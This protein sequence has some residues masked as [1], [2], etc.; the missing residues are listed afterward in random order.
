M[1][2]SELTELQRYLSGRE[3]AEMD[4]L[5][6]KGTP[7][8]EPLTGS[9]QTEAYHS[10]ADFLF[11]GG[12][13][14]GGKTDLLVG[15]ALTRHRQSVIFRREYG[16]L[17]AIIHRVQNILSGRVGYNGQEKI[18]RLKDDRHLRFG[19]CQ[20]LGDEERF[21]GQPHDL[22]GFDEITHFLEAQFRFLVGWNR[23]DVTGQRCRV[24]ATGNPPRDAEG[25][26]VIK[27]W[28]PWLDPDHT[29]PALPGELRWFTTG[30]EGE[31]VELESGEPFEQNGE[32]IVPKSR[33]FI[34]SSVEDNPFL[35][36][37]GYKAMLQALPEPLRSQMLKGDF[38]AGKDDDPWQVIPTE[39]VKL[40]Q[41]RWTDRRP[42][43]AEMTA[44]GVDVARGGA[45]KTVLSPR[46]GHWFAEQKVQPGTATPDG[47][48]A[49]SFVM[50]ALRDGAPVQVDVIGV[51]GSVYDHLKGNGIDCHAMNGSE[52]SEQRDR[53]GQLTFA[54]R[55]AEWWWAM[56]EDL[57]PDYGSGLALPPDRNLLVDLCAPRWKLTTR[58][59]QVESKEDIVKRIGRSPDRGDAA[60][61][62]LPTFAKK[63]A[64]GRGVTHALGGYNP[65][66]W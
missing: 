16:Q 62:A 6:T 10:P 24:V 21:Q 20:H 59:V 64:R 52:K 3:R 43:G 28:A 29:K 55:R 50:S 45:D 14:G 7:A 49:A 35:M 42:D 17:Q 32:T 33:T 60:V 61:L 15:L 11:Y 58:G 36:Q 19:A 34:P 5:L 66:R 26:W 37:T 27:F 57:D 51:G 41:E 23:T 39:W 22:V 56:R 38:A 53:S 54:N 47:P 2:L 44:L 25:E 18:W 31:D 8:W 65:H 13:A 9:P 30:P 12:S 46:Y 40:A 1:T 63:K 4:K 48:V